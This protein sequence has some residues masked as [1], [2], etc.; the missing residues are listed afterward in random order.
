MYA[1]RS[2]RLR[3]LAPEP[4]TQARSRRKSPSP[5]ESALWQALRGRQVCGA[6]FRRQHSVG[7]FI[8]DFWCP[9]HR[10]AIEVEDDTPEQVAV[11]SE[12]QF[13]LEAHDIRL[14]RIR[15]DDILFQP[16]AVLRRIS[17]TLTPP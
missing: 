14:L 16:E 15:S 7:S 10:L 4:V 6:K 9:E 13:W 3:K 12:R 2:P 11:E 5:A 8:L 17:G 1:H